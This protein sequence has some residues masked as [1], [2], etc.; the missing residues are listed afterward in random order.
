MKRGEIWW[1]NLP[2]PAGS[3]PGYRRPV[4]VM[5]SNR[6][7]DTA[8]RTVVVVPLT[9]SVRLADAPGNLLIRRGQAGLAESS[10]VNVTQILAVDKRLLERLIGEL[11]KTRLAE[12]EAGLRLVLGL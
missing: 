4:L 6:F 11:P 2:Q 1:A 8:I 9:R 12:V 3:G 5:S 7:N 10:V